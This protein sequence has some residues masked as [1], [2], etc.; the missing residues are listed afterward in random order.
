MWRICG[1]RFARSNYFDS[2]TLMKSNIA[3]PQ[4]KQIGE[5]N[6]VIW[7]DIDMVFKNIKMIEIIVS[8][9]YFVYYFCY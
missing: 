6:L 7:Y 9:K 3:K 1:S 8:Y 5:H 2:G 4:H